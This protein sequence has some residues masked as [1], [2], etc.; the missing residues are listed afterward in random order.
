MSQGFY[1]NSQSDIFIEHSG[2]RIRI[3]PGD[4]NREAVILE[5]ALPRG[6]GHQTAPH[7]QRTLLP[8][9]SVRICSRHLLWRHNL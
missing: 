8:L 9:Q 5:E 1:A 7:C 3:L 2:G 4:R 6:Q